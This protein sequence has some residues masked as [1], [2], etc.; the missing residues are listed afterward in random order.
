MQKS[1]S[2]SQSSLLPEPEGVEGSRA[3]PLPK[4]VLK[5]PALPGVVAALKSGVAG[6]RGCGSG[7]K[8]AAAAVVTPPA[9]SA[10]ARSCCCSS[11]CSCSCSCSCCCPTSPSARPRLEKTSSRLAGS[12]AAR[13][14]EGEAGVL[15]PAPLA[16]SMLPGV[17]PAICWLPVL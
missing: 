1:L 8:A 6:A 16:L 11:S 3:V 17:T 9:V 5:R 7:C 4:G 13:P 12:S 10:A 14:A 15:A 2:T